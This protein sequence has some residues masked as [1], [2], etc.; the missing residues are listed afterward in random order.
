[1][2]G[3]VSY[4]PSYFRFGNI[5]RKHL[6]FPGLQLPLGLQTDS[7]HL[8]SQREPSEWLSEGSGTRPTSE[9]FISVTLRDTIRHL[10]GSSIWHVFYG[11]SIFPTYHS[12]LRNKTSVSVIPRQEWLESIEQKTQT[13]LSAIIGHCTSDIYGIPRMVVRVM[14]VWSQPPA[15]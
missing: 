15:P 12:H 7:L 4:Q 10:K 2:N 8:D 6:T 3:I 13:T 9:L 14:V 1:M 11:H 5:S